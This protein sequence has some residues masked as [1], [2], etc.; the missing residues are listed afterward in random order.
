[1]TILDSSEGPSSSVTQMT[2]GVF[3]SLQAWCVVAVTSRRPGR[4]AGIRAA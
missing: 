1:M 4:A 2:P 3:L